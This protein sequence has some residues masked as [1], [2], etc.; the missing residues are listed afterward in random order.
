M[1]R[2]FVEGKPDLALVKALGVSRQEASMA[3]NK[4]KV[5][6]IARKNPP[7]VGLVDEDPD[8]ELPGYL[9]DLKKEDLGQN[10]LLY[11]DAK[12]GN[13]II[14]LCPRLEEWLLK[15]CKQDGVKLGDFFLPDKPVELHKE[16]PRHLPKLEKLVAHLLELKNPALLLLQLHLLE[17]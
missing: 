2:V 7:A 6:H 8:E 15:V 3:G 10:L 1:K 17:K 9:R 16:W 14:A 12:N 11:R 5:C 4:G 13:K